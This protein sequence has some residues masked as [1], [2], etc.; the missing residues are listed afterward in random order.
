MLGDKDGIFIK[1][2]GIIL[3]LIR[4]FI[5]S[6][7][8]AGPI[9]DH[10]A[11]IMDGNRRYAKKKKLEQ[12]LGHDAGFVTL[13]SLLRYCYELGIKYITVYAFSIENFKRKPEEVEKLM[14]LMLEKIEGLLKE[15]SIVNKYGVR[16][17]FIGNLNL[18]HEPV[19][20]A[21]E[22]A[23][24]ATSKN[25]KAVLLICVAYTSTDEITHSVQET[26]KKTSYDKDCVITRDE[27]D[28]KGII[29]VDDLD[30]NMYMGV[31]PDPE[32]IIR[33]SGETRLSNFLLWQ[34]TYCL[35]YS[36]RAL[37]PE[38][39]LWHVLFSVLNFQRDR[40][41]LQKKI[42]QT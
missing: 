7:V 28:E 12:E 30:K 40:S 9:P 35:L 5:F 16:V 4:K 14:N 24:L 1:L 6:I 27:K 17:Y 10:I 33:S 3:T 13:M 36:P 11:F 19:R 41:Y 29:K 26:F 21:A 25:S 32:I 37:W 18:L 31:A 39:G 42:K 38:I 2:L 22:K 15:E 23:M 8:S 34:S 20:V